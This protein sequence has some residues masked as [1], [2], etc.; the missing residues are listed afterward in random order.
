[1]HTLPMKL[2]QIAAVVGMVLSFSKFQ[3]TA[4][5]LSFSSSPSQVIE[6]TENTGFKMYK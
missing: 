6:V 4:P 2:G 1:M 5:L 3:G